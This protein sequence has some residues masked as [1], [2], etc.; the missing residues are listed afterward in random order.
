MKTDTSKSIVFFI[1]LVLSLFLTACNEPPECK[2]ED[3]AYNQAACES[4]RQ[5]AIV[6]DK[7]VVCDPFSPWK[8]DTACEALKGP[9]WTDVIGTVQEETNGA[10][11]MPGLACPD[12]DSGNDQ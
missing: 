8:D 4:L 10:L 9:D 6:A 1:L 2:P 7:W 12:A 5:Q 3:A 11:C